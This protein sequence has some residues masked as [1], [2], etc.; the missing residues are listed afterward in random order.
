MQSEWICVALHKWGPTI[1]CQNKLRNNGFTL[2]DRLWCKHSKCACY[3]LEIISNLTQQYT[4]MK[5]W[6][7]GP[8]CQMNLQRKYLNPRVPWANRLS[9]VLML[10]AFDEIK[11]ISKK[12]IRID[13]NWK[14]LRVGGILGSNKRRY[15]RNMT[16]FSSGHWKIPVMHALCTKVQ[17][18]AR[19]WGWDLLTKLGRSLDI[20]DRSPSVKVC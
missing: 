18:R 17:E 19:C 5:N 7:F 13:L 6:T 15:S 11:N 20:T 4:N 12:A 10:I 3:R 9:A 8:Q 2:T 14:T 16:G 1:A